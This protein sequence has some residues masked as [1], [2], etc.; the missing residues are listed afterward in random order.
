MCVQKTKD[1]K[2]EKK[3]NR[4]YWGG[5][6]TYNYFLFH[7]P[8]MQ[9]RLE[10]KLNMSL[11]FFPVKIYNA[12]NVVFIIHNL[13]RNARAYFILLRSSGNLTPSYVYNAMF[14]K[15]FCKYIIKNKVIQPLSNVFENDR[16]C[17]LLIILLFRAN[18]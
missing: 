2:I 12:L 6:C 4:N 17:F 18:E 3:I 11:R 14:E 16:K 8:Y 7:F 10:W 5:W 15:V 1:N 13:K 9:L